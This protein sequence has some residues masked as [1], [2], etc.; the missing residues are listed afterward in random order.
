MFLMK[1]VLLGEKGVG[2]FAVHKLGRKIA[3]Y[4]FFGLSSIIFESLVLGTEWI[5]FTIIYGLVGLMI[6]GYHAALSSVIM[7]ICNPKIG[8]TQYSLISSIS[9]IGEWTG[10]TLGGTFISLIGYGRAFLYSG[11][12]F[13][14][15]LIVLYLMKIKKSKTKAK[16]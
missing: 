9:N 11:W 16:K 7:D 12:F 2:R 3:L 14:P 8:A 13:G 1:I 15:A 5:S 4:L 10:G 6:G